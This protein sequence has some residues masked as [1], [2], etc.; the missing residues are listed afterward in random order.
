MRKSIVAKL[1]LMTVGLCSLVVAVLYIGQ[2]LF[3]ERFYVQQKVRSVQTALETFTSESR[4]D[5]ADA[6]SAYQIE[7]QFYDDYHTWI[8]RLDASGYLSDTDN[9]EAVVRLEDV[10]DAP[11]LSGASLTVPLYTIMNIEELAEDNPLRPD[12]FVRPGESIAIEGLLIDDRLVPQRVGRSPSSLRDENHLENSPLVRTE[13]EMVSRFDNAV[14]YREHYPS[15]L[16]N[17]TVTQIRIPEGTEQ[18][19]YTHHLFLERIKSFQANLLYGQFDAKA[20][21]VIDYE[22]NNIPYKIFIKRLTDRS[23]DVSYLFA[24]TSL[25][26]VNEAAGVMRHYYGYIALGALLLAAW[27]S[28]YYA[29]RIARPL[30]RVNDAAQRMA[31]LDFSARIP[32]ASEDEI[33]QLSRSINGLAHMLH[34]HIQ[35]L[36]RD[37]EREQRLER[38]RKEFISGISHELKTPLSLMESCLYI[39]ED[40]PDSP[41]RAYYFAAMK[42]E[43]QK[44]SL[45]IGDML[46]LAKYESGT[47]RMEVSPFRIDALLERVCAKHAEE[48]AG[49]RLQLR[50]R[51][52]PVETIGNPR[53]IEQVAVNLL[54]NA[55]RYTPEGQAICVE[56]AEEAGAVRIAIENRGAHIPDEQLDKIWDRFYRI[57]P[58]RHRSTGGT[59]LGLAIC[60]QIL[61]LHGAS[62]GAV[63]TANGVQF[64]F[65]LTPKQEA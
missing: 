36:E 5:A 20:H 28:F 30:L 37:I 4:E 11:A 14:E 52:V 48:L 51:F 21:T 2:V 53:R 23:E 59:G 19:R 60:K 15:L 56:T 3:F 33:G 39:I 9:F 29:R 54:T 38:T 26:P 63:N 58:S 17:G 32:A 8:A 61:E 42:D 57:E 62:Y 50:T 43:V 18:S 45:L 41:K 25:Q 1:F 49:K 24:M 47:Y 31:E 22:E 16:V 46:E 40:K 12:F 65:T 7:R 44:M 64:Y 34:D 55:I 6:R 35:R 10:T 13:Y 27:I